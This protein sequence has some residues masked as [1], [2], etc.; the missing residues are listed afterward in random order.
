MRLLFWFYL[1][2]LGMVYALSNPD[3]K[4]CTK[5]TERSRTSVLLVCVA[6]TMEE[7]EK[8]SRSS[9][10]SSFS[11]SSF[12]S[13]T[14]LQ[15]SKNKSSPTDMASKVKCVRTA[16]LSK[17]PTTPD[18]T[19]L[20]NAYLHLS[21]KWRS[22]HSRV[23]KLISAW[24]NTTEKMY[25]KRRTT[26]SRCKLVKF[27]EVSDRVWVSFEAVII[28]KTLKEEWTDKKYFY[29]NYNLV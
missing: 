28:E 24:P 4:V 8:E 1:P 22:S 7:E 11:L 26:L 27:S 13:V 21:A 17:S 18:T 29:D 2:S 19:S 14:F 5:C 16:D 23:T 15:L 3:R 10:F 6:G 12:S 9:W 25:K 20:S